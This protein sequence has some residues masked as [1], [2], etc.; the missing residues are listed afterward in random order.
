MEWAPLFM[1]WMAQQ[2]TKIYGLLLIFPKSGYD[3]GFSILYGTWVVPFHWA[4][5][6]GDDYIWYIPSLRSPWPRL[7]PGPGRGSCCISTRVVRSTSWTHRLSSV[8]TR[9]LAGLN[10]IWMAEISGISWAIY[11]K[12]H[13][14]CVGKYRWIQPPK[15]GLNKWPTDID[16]SKN[17]W[18]YIVHLDKW[19]VLLRGKMIYMCSGSVLW[20]CPLKLEG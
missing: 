5:I 19:S 18:W 11:P 9:R 8:R 2:S 12:Y 4:S 3:P 20:V 14:A 17:I 16:G 10:G 1:K 15:N 6:K 7:L 13:G